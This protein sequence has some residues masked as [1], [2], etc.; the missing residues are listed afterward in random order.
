M[1]IKIKRGTAQ[2]VSAASLEER[3]FAFDKENN[4]L[5]V[6]SPTGKIKVTNNSVYTASDYAT[7][8][9]PKVANENADTGDVCPLDANGYIPT[10]KLPTQLWNEVEHVNI[11]LPETGVENKL[12]VLRS[13]D[14][15]W[16]YKN[17]PG[18]KQLLKWPD[19]IFDGGER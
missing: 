15:L 1:V 2:Q 7:K 9:L 19:F 12:Y 18:W 6:G 13:D 3:E 14:T 11:T 10:E 5:Y 4:D 17:G 16:R 8:F